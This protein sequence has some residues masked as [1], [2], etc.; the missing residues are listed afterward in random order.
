MV[1]RPFRKRMY[2]MKDELMEMIGS[3]KRKVKT[4]EETFKELSS[5]RHKKGKRGSSKNDLEKQEECKDQ[6]WI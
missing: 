2:M 1:N 4:L 5:D 3:L 6:P